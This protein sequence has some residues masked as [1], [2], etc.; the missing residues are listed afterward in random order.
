M[1]IRGGGDLPEVDVTEALLSISRCH[2]DPGEQDRQ[3]LIILRAVWDSGGVPVVVDDSGDSR[4]GADRWCSWWSGRD[5]EGE[6]G[7]RGWA[8]NVTTG[9]GEPLT[10]GC[11]V[12]RGGAADRVQGLATAC[13]HS[14]TACD[15]SAT[16]CDL[17]VRLGQRLQGRICSTRIY[18]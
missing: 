16:A 17:R 10:T 5:S 15:H 14:A 18:P 8:E 11:R 3:T 1:K 9:R 4:G 6:G 2:D 12:N 13:D 7:G